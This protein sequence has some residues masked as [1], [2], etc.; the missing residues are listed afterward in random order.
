MGTLASRDEIPLSHQN[1]DSPTYEWARKWRHGQT[2]K[3]T[4][5]P[6]DSRALEPDAIA[7][8]ARAAL[9]L[10]L[11]VAIQGGINEAHAR[12]HK[13]RDEELGMRARNTCRYVPDTFF[14]ARDRFIRWRDELS[15]LQEAA[16][17]GNTAAFLD[18]VAKVK[19]DKQPAASF[20]RG[21]QLALEAG[22]HTAARELSADGARRYPEDAE[23]N[24]QAYILSP[25]KVISRGMANNTPHRANRDWLKAHDEEYRGQWV[26][27]RD[28]ELLGAAET[29]EEL[30]SRLGSTKGILLTIV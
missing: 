11:C 18:A 7:R 12:R 27:L 23:L 22:A 16:K 5:P 10:C 28:G 24:K 30:T 9:G 8:A 6:A 13:D 25:P 14:A 2:G 26:A 4:I 15:Q 19:W 20:V 21:V 17:E 3:V 29:M 1:P